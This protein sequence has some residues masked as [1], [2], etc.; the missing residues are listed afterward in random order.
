[1]TDQPATEDW[2]DSV[3]RMFEARLINQG[4]LRSAVVS[5]ASRMIDG[6]TDK[7]AGAHPLESLPAREFGS[8]PDEVP[9]MS[10]QSVMAMP[11]NVASEDND[12]K[13]NIVGNIGEYYTHVFSDET[14]STVFN[15]GFYTA[16]LAVKAGLIDP[17]L[18]H[19]DTEHMRELVAKSAPETDTQD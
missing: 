15:V 10:W 8:A 3:E 14:P 19:L 9:S 17:E 5:Q 13:M 1:M 6:I 18:F 11:T 12:W 7:A 2:Q 16:V 4:E